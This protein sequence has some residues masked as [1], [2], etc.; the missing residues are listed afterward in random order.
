MGNYHEIDVPTPPPEAPRASRTILPRRAKARETSRPTRRSS[1][2]S[3]V[4]PEEDLEADRAGLYDEIVLEDAR[5]SLDDGRKTR[6]SPTAPAQA[7][8]LDFP[9]CCLMS[10]TPTREAAAHSRPRRTRRLGLR[11]GRDLGLDLAGSG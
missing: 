4:A 10:S 1:K 7:E 9:P 5:R 3:G 2:P 11:L 8:S 6:S